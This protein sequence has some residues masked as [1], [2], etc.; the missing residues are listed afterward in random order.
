MSFTS[1]SKQQISLKKLVG[2]AHTKN[3]AEFFNESKAS[4]ITISFDKVIG[5]PIPSPPSSPS[6][7]DIHQDV[8]EY[9]RCPVVALPE[10]IQNGKYHGFAL[11]L[12]AAYQTGSSNPEAG[13]GSFLNDTEIHSTLGNI[14]LISTAY[15]ALYE[16]KVFY[17]GD[18]VNG[19]GTRIP[20]LDN[21]NW[22]LDY[23]NGILFQQTPPTDAAE[24]PSY[25][26]VFVYIGKMASQKASSLSSMWEPDPNDSNNLIPTGIIDGDTG[27]FAADFNIELL[28]N[29]IIDTF[30]YTATNRT[31]AQDL[32][33]EFDSN[34]NIVPKE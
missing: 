22:Y 28:D 4:G 24:N 19:G 17:G 16:A 26:E 1:D 25:V 30:K 11:K 18:T 9:V 6:V 7:Y 15:G 31:D 27:L 5:E 21:R 23:Y 3:E 13:S 33:F 8:V 2:K 14:Q 29:N 34:G 12:P 20:V 10:S 32:Y